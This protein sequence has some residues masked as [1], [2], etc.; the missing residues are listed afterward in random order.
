MDAGAESST[1][2]RVRTWA[3]I[4]VVVVF[5][6][7]CHR[8]G[9]VDEPMAAPPQ[10]RPAPAPPPDPWRAG[11]PCSGDL[12]LAARLASVT[13]QATRNRPRIEVL[14]DID[15]DG[16]PERAITGASC[17]PGG[18]AWEIYLSARGCPRRA[19]Q[20]FGMA[21]HVEPFVPPPRPVYVRERATCAP[22]GPPDCG[23]WTPVPLR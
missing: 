10:A 17:G 22:G 13:D 9:E 7:G 2:A 20:A 8:R 18:C 3:L 21:I 16:A 1:L 12:A 14:P 5:A 15:G 4:G 6:A 11:P 19:G 23:V